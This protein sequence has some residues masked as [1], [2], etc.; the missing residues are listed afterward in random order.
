[1]LIGAYASLASILPQR[2]VEWYYLFDDS[3]ALKKDTLSC[4]TV[5]KLGR[6]FISQRVRDR[7][8][9]YKFSKNKRSI[10]AE[11]VSVSQLISL[12]FRVTNYIIYHALQKCAISFL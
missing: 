11:R 4:K 7:F 1:M 2:L 8:Y 5:K 10:Q 6:R 3:Q 9:N 12:C